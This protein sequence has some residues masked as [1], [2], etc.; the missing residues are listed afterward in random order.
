MQKSI[1]LGAKVGF[2]TQDKDMSLEEFEALLD[3][4]LTTLREENLARY[5][6]AHL[7]R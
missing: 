2:A 6:K 7:P 1:M 3:K 5:Y 4:W